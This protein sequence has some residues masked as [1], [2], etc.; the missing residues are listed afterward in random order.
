MLP[1]GVGEPHQAMGSPTPTGSIARLGAGSVNL[2]EPRTPR[3]VVLDDRLIHRGLGV[4]PAS[5]G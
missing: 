1:V 5:P 2:R 4:A 3:A